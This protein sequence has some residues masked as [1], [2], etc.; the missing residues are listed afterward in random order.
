MKINIQEESKKELKESEVEED[1]PVHLMPEYLKLMLG[2][3]ESRP[4][5][6]CL[7]V[8]TI[9]LTSSTL[10]LE[11]HAFRNLVFHKILGST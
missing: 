2:E 4:I 5:R 1:E 9:G 8:D 3:E 7:Y 6:S 11:L 10:D